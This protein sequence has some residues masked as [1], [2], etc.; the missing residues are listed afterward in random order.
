MLTIERPLLNQMLQH[1]QAEYPL[2]GC[3]LLAGKEDGWITAV[4]PIHNI[5]QS[6]TKY[7]MDPRQQLHAFLDMEAKGWQLAAIF[8]SHP[9]GPDHP[10]PT[11]IALAYYP[12]ATNIIIS[13]RNRAAPVVRAF[14]IKTQTVTEQ[15]MTIV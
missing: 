7:E 1:L 5:L 11:D 4:Y 13:L 3:G 15:T 9:Q 2:E 12:D 10:S 14:I 6:P 8:H